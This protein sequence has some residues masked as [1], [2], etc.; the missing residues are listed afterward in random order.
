MCGISCVFVL[1][2]HTKKRVARS[3]FAPASWPYEDNTP[4]PTRPS[5]FD[6]P[7]QDMSQLR[8]RHKLYSDLEASLDQIKH[9]GPDSRGHWI[10]DDNRIGTLVIPSSNT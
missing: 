3:P 6:S 2:E 4:A 10:S 7:F 8:E 9:R 5:P 1:R